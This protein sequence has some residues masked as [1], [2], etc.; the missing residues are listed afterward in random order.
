[1][2]V[3]GND[4]HGRGCFREINGDIARIGS[5]VYLDL[6]GGTIP[7]PGSRVT[8]FIV[9]SV[10]FS[11]KEKFSVV[12]CFGDRNYTY[13]FGHDPTASMLEVTLTS[14]L[15]GTGGT[16]YGG[17]LKQAVA[18]YRKARLSMSKKL[19]KLT[20]GSLYMEGFLVGM[21]SAT[22]DQEHNLQS[23]TFVIMLVKAQG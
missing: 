14:F 7:E 2:Y 11:Q 4:K 21:T 10:S 18:A 23:I 22:Q 9:T 5:A 16:S 8:P 3:F 20:M 1:M 13:A 17:A 19:V 15:A 12:Q 6:A